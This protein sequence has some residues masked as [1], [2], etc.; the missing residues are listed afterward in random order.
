MAYII[1]DKNN[2]FYNLDIVAHKTKS[3]DKIAI[4]L[5]DNAYGHGLLE[6]AGMAQEYG[7]KQAVV[8]YKQEAKKIKHL[9]E[10][11]LV[12]ADIPQ[13]KSKTI[14]YTINSLDSIK[15]FPKGCLVELKVNTGMNRNGIE[16][17][18]LS[19]AF[20][21]IDTHRLKLRG[22]F[23]HHGCAD[24][25][26]GNYEKQT[27]RFLAVKKEV[28]E[29]IKS[30]GWKKIRFHSAN[31]ATLFREKDFDEDIARIGIAAYGCLEMPKELCKVELKPVLALYAQ[32]N[33]TR[34]VKK[35]QSVG[36][37]ASFTAKS[38]VVVSNYN[39][40]YGDGFLRSCSNSYQT[41]QGVQIVGRVSMDNSS[42]ISDA[43][44]LLI[45][46]DAKDVAK[47]AGTISYEVLTSL[48]PHLKRK[49][50]VF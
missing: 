49:V 48:K 9:F 12:L 22:V 50:A 7:L 21:L 11:I 15:K 23:T 44:E 35:G 8:Q 29:L 30:Y 24:E 4:V 14:S 13:K 28:K 34:I 39:F 43:D 33:S 6:M 1:L 46:D 2:F 26:D 45:F 25:L 38:D 36:Y 16:M 17:E 31:S 20:R 19:E 42:F 47:F 3:K 37:G 32:K 27:K 41:P 40:G 18:Q 5:K 10:H